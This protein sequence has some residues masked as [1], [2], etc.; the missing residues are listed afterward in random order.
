MVMLIISMQRNKWWW[1][2]WH[3]K[4][5]L[6]LCSLVPCSSIRPGLRDDL[7]ALAGRTSGWT[8][9]IGLQAFSDVWPGRLSGGCG[10]AVSP[11]IMPGHLG[12][13]VDTRLVHTELHGQPHNFWDSPSTL[14]VV[15][16][17]LMVSPTI[18]NANPQYSF[19]SSPTHTNR[20]SH[21][22]WGSPARLFG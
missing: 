13:T 2:W 4:L 8:K 9:S 22:I 21:D 17:L 1:L 10:L 20:Q 5:W 6:V 15:P 16:H 19:R 11:K 12:R 7:C 18:F 14:W 3:I